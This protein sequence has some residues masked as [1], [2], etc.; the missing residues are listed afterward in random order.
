MPSLDDSG[1]DVHAKLSPELVVDLFKRSPITV[2]HRVKAPVL[3][4]LGA[5]DRR[6]PSSQGLAWLHSLPD[7][8]PRKVRLFPKDGHPLDTAEAE[9]DLM[10]R[11]LEFLTEYVH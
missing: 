3:M 1:H 8:T 5:T 11:V 4:M 10:E 2:A 7:D 6:V 9:R